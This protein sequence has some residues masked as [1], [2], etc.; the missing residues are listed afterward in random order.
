MSPGVGRVVVAL[1]PLTSW[2][3]V[4]LRVWE[5]LVVAQ[6]RVEVGT[7]DICYVVTIGC[8]YLTHTSSSRKCKGRTNQ[9]HQG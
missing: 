7:C 9:M 6:Q 8:S 1:R 5:N 2:G 4:E 3:L